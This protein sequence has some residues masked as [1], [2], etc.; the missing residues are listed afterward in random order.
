[1]R[2]AGVIETFFCKTN[3]YAQA[4]VGGVVQPPSLRSRTEGAYGLVINVGGR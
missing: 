3:P 4:A 2:N 1:M